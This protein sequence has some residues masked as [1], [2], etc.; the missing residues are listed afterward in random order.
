V[1][2]WTAGRRFTEPSPTFLTRTL[3]ITEARV[4][5]QPPEPTADI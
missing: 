3:A 4:I 5:I 2:T 1:D